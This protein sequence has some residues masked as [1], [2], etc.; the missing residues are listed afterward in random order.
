MTVRNI[1]EVGQQAAMGALVPPNPAEALGIAFLFILGLIAVIALVVAVGKMN[2]ARHSTLELVAK[3]VGGRTV[4]ATFLKTEELEFAISGRGARLESF[5]GGKHSPPHTRVVVD[6]R[7][8]FPGTLHILEQGFG[9]AFLKLFGAQDLLIGDRRFDEEYVIKATP[10]RLASGL[11]SP[12]RR[13]DVIR[14]VRSLRGYPG[15][16][17]DLN[18]RIVTVTV[19][20]YLREY[21][22]FMTLIQATSEFVGFLLG[23]SAGIQMDAVQ[24]TSGGACPVCGTPMVDLVV[25]CESCRTPHH[26]EC[27]QYMGRCST[28]ACPG[29]K[30]VA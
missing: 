9:L 17:F 15:P 3:K 23:P 4:P 8:S 14:T 28:Y 18:Q 6:L 13:S 5:A 27:W 11:F 24:V 21:D 2:A 30:A 10:E 29:Q 16:T 25:R 22:E 7:D 19:R 20:K 1:E 12:D 26:S